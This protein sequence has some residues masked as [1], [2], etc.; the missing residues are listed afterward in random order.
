MSPFPS[1]FSPFHSPL[2]FFFFE[3]RSHVAQ[4]GLELAIAKD[5][6]E[7]LIL[8]HAHLKCQN[9]TGVPPHRASHFI[10]QIQEKAK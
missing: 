10:L 7:L 9:Y 6:L 5:G 3:I 4:V 2:F 1:S 8:W